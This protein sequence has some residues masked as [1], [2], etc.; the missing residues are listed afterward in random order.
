[1]TRCDPVMI[2]VWIENATECAQLGWRGEQLVARSRSGA[3]MALA[4]KLVAAGMPDWPWQAVGDLANP[5][6]A[7]GVQIPGSFPG[8][9]RQTARKRCGQHRRGGR[10]PNVPCPRQSTR[11]NV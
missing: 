5:S 1:M 7:D 2:I 9:T 6:S 11:R 10:L 4:R 3:V 8:V